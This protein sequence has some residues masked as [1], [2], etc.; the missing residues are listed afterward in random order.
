MLLRSRLARE[1]M[2]NDYQEM[3]LTH[4]V[5]A[6]KNMEM[7]KLSAPLVC[8]SSLHLQLIVNL[9]LTSWILF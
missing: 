1:H 8:V 4:F 7:L 6:I 2:H 3:C 9:F 5:S